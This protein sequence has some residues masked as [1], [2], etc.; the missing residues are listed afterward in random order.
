MDIFEMIRS[1]LVSVF[2]AS[3]Y[4]Y[5]YFIWFKLE[6]GNFFMKSLSTILNFTIEDQIVP[7]PPLSSIFH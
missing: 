4:S 5:A 1:T 7:N 3:F 6:G 2:M